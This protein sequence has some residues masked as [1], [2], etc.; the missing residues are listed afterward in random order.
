MNFIF[1]EDQLALHDSVQ[2]FLQAQVTPQW[3]RQ[4][5]E[6]GPLQDDVLWQKIVDLGLTV[7]LVPEER[8]G[9]GLSE[10]DAVLLAEACGRVALPGTLIENAL[11]AVPL[12]AALANENAQC[13]QLLSAVASGEQRL[14]IQ[15]SL[16]PFVED[17]D[18]ADWLM[19]QREDK[20]YLLNRTEL[21][22]TPCKSL[23]PSRRLFQ[24]DTQGNNGL[25]I[26]EGEKGAS[27]WRAVVNRAALSTAAQLLGLSQTL[28]E[29]AVSYSRDREQFG[30]PIGSFQAIKHH[31]ADCAVKTEFVRAPLYRAAYTVSKLP[32][33]ADIAVSHAKIA[34]GEAALLAAKNAIQVHG[35]MGYTWECDLHI[36]MK[37]AWVLDKLWGDAGFHKCRVNQWLL[38]HRSL[39]GAGNTFGRLEVQDRF[40]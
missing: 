19:V 12:L 8:E 40:V 11:V 33:G 15:H 14:V 13:A 18:L 3:I 21:A 31:L 37:R 22:I 34:A 36:Y 39:L 2:R 28:I 26:A 5:W 32:V 6:N 20:A 24:I 4:R 27:L 7:L 29:Q 38:N 17:A 9:L 23:D 30:K 25:L 10:M 1:T 35:A 16:N